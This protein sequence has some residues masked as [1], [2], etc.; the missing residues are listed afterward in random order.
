MRKV[1]HLF[2]HVRHLYMLLIYFQKKFYK[3]FSVYVV[4]EDDEC[5]VGGQ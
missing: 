2:L 5:S 3:I 1:R 4:S